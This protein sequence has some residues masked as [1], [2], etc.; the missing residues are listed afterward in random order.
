M[1]KPLGDDAQITL[2]DNTKLKG[3]LLS[4]T[5]THILAR[6]SDKIHRIS[7]SEIDK[8][9][10]EGYTLFHVK[11]L[12]LMPL[13]IFD[14]FTIYSNPSTAMKVGFGI[15]GAGKLTSIFAGDPEVVFMP[16]FFWR[17]LDKL[18]LHSRFP[19]GLTPEQWEQMCQF[20]SQADFIKH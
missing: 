1:S 18:R 3:E 19:H 17:D 15:M 2:E 4:V 8:I 7:L 14:I 5:E 9:Y 11:S 13:S 16:P 6:C 20:H 12:L 10:I